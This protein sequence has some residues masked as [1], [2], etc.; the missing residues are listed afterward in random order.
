MSLSRIALGALLLTLAPPAL[1]ADDVV[2]G[3]IYPLTGNAAQVGLDAKAAYEVEA[4]IING[5][6][7]PIPMLLGK[8]GGLAKLGGAKIKLVF[9]DSQ[10]DPQ[11]ARPA[12]GPVTA[13]YKAKQGKGLNDNTS[14]QITALQILAD[15]ID[16]AGSAKP[17]DIRTALVATDVKGI[18]MIMPWAGVKFDETGQNTAGTPVIQQV[19]NG[20]YVT[21]WP[22][23]VAS[24]DVVW[25]DAK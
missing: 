4:D 3:V 23:D 11:K 19:R 25:M 1:A 22:F 8:G 16:R 10:G 7:D 2:I 14:R 20:T 18:D 12:I 13:L 24:T 17:A 6:H 5:T 9:A 21:V 15:A